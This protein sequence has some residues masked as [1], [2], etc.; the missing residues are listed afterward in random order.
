M[1]HTA[2]RPKR[3]KVKL[4]GGG[5][6]FTR[7]RNGVKGGTMKAMRRLARKLKKAQRKRGR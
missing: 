5:V 6:R 2:Q 7:D 3:R 1:G 4:V